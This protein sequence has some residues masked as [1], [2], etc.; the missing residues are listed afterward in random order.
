MQ[1][2][3]AVGESNEACEDS[4]SLEQQLGKREENSCSTAPGHPMCHP[5]HYRVS[6]KCILTWACYI[7][8][9]QKPSV[10]LQRP[11]TR[12]QQASAMHSS[13]RTFPRDTAVKV[14]WLRV[15][16]KGWLIDRLPLSSTSHPL[17]L[18]LCG[19]HQK[20][21]Q[22]QPRLSCPLQQHNAVLNLHYPTLTLSQQCPKLSFK[23]AFSFLAS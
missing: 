10:S 20:E 19:S 22:E 7:P 12:V 6:D 4:L 23:S 14:T 9:H 16:P 1:S 15:R 18:N 5:I 2:G 21:K 3:S 13:D 8:Y 17:L 11:Q